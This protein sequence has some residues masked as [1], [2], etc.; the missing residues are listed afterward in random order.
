[1]ATQRHGVL[2]AHNNEAFTL[3][4]A[5]RRTAAPDIPFP[6]A[7][8][9]NLPCPPHTLEHVRSLY[10]KEKTVVGPEFCDSLCYF[11]RSRE[12]LVMDLF[13]RYL[14]AFGLLTNK[15][16]AKYHLPN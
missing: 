14:L 4:V 3:G 13:R 2:G 8:Q 7:N 10:G 5:G 6:P 15:L 9:S 1:M 16:L 12:L 11:F